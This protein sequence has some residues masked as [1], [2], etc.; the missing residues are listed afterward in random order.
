VLERAEYIPR[1]ASAREIAVDVQAAIR[2]GLL[3]SGAALP[4]V[5]A[6]ARELAISPAT[7]NAAYRELRQ[8]GLLISEGHRG[9]RVS[10]RPP[11]AGRPAL[12]V[13]DGVR[14]VCNGNPDPALLPPLDWALEAGVGGPHLYGQSMAFAPLLQ[15]AAADFATSGIDA[16]AQVVVSGAMDG[17]DRLLSVGLHP[18]DHV[19]VEDPTY[20]ELIDLLRAMRLTPVGVPIDSEGPITEHVAAALPDLRAAVLT[21][22]AHNPTGA[23]ISPA[24]SRQLREA[25]ADHPD[26]L[27]IENDHSALVAGPCSPRVGPC[28]PARA[29]VSAA[30]SRSSVPPPPPLE[31]GDITRLAHDLA[32]VLRPKGTTRGA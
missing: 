5:R 31:P 1:G 22:R 8:R 7:V 26:L 27:V 16:S 21:P 30:A 25:L 24:R 9:M 32:A 20:A 13:P 18:G 17:I 10:L 19:L 11:I 29:T 2:R 23:S 4:S 12:T 14:D 6:L 15:R 28:E 3:E